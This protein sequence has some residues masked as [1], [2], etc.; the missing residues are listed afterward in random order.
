MRRRSGA[1]SG[2]IAVSDSF[3]GTVLS[4]TIAQSR[5]ELPLREGEELR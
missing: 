5:V 4:E 1:E 2:I 3:R